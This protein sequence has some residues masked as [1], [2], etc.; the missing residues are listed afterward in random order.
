MSK[1]SFEQDLTL[2]KQDIARLQLEDAIDLFLAR[3]WISAVTLAG[4]AA[5]IF[6]D[7][8]KLQGE[9]SVVDETWRHIEEVRAATGL[10]YAGS[11]TKKEE[12]I[13]DW[14]ET[15]NTL[16]HHGSKDQDPLT[17]SAFDAAFEMINRANIDG[18]CLGVCA[19]NRQ[20]Y[21]NWCVENIFWT[22]SSP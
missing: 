17:F 3:K 20:D 12:A 22:T 9:P 1:Y 21:E 13:H 7:L 15:R 2:T 10:P 5:E 4:A 8:L 16:K 19:E 18:E 6:K 14:N 11:R